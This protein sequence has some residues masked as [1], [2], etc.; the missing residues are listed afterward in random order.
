MRAEGQDRGAM[1]ELGATHPKAVLLQQDALTKIGLFAGIGG[2]GGPG[3]QAGGHQPLTPHLGHRK[4]RAALTDA[5]PEEPGYEAAAM[6]DE[7]GGTEEVADPFLADAGAQE[8]GKATDVIGMGMADEDMG[9][10]MGKARRHPSALPQV[11]EQ[12]AALM[13]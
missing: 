9:H 12:A 5:I 11:E 4:D 13:A 1:I 2:G 8:P 7:S 3:A 6:V 10:L